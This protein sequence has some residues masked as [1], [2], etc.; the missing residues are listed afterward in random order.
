M[1]P[2]K[3]VPD[4]LEQC[5]RKGIPCA[6]IQSA[7]FS[8]F[9]EDRRRLE[10]NLITISRRWN[11]RFMS[12]NCIGVINLNK[13]LVLFFLPIYPEAMK[14]GPVSVI[15]QSGSLIIDIMRLLM[16]ENIDFN[17]AISIGNKL[18]LNECDYLEFLISDPQTRCIAVYLEN[19]SDGRRLMSL[20]RQTEKPVI[21]LKA[22]RFASSHQIGR[23]RTTALAGGP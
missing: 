9:T 7:G 21:V 12:P 20:A 17:K 4:A 19:F 6:I 18:D 3:A 2:A 15:L 16:L 11:I 13:G 1:I 22:N 10:E 14:K 5:G 8:E 23:F